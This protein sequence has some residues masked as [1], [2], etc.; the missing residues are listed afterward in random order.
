MIDCILKARREM[1]RGGL[2]CGCQG[3]SGG[4]CQGDG[5][6]D[7]VTNSVKGTVPLT[8]SLPDNLVTPL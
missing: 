8:T 5:S 4:G 3:L 6:F 7:T 2:Y 1:N